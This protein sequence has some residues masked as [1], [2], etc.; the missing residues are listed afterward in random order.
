MKV[1]NFYHLNL[2]SSIK[3]EVNMTSRVNPASSTPLPPIAEEVVN[4][5]ESTINNVAGVLKVP[6]HIRGFSNYDLSE[7]TVFN[8]W[9]QITGKSF[10]SYG[11]SPVELRPFEL[12]EHLEAKGGIGKQIFGVYRMDGNLITDLG[13]PFDHTL[14]LALFVAQRHREIPFPFMRQAI[15]VV[16][17][18]EN[19]QAG[20]FRAFYQ[21]DVDVIA[22]KLELTSDAEC[23]ASLMTALTELNIGTFTTYINHIGIV[24]GILDAFAIPEDLRKNVLTE[25]DKA[26]KVSEEELFTNLQKI[27]AGIPKKEIENLMEVFSFR[28]PIEK[29]P[30]ENYSE[31]TKQAYSDL[32]EIVDTLRAF[33]INT[34]AIQVAPNIVRG[35]DY[36]TGLVFETFL[37]GK[38]QYG[39]IMSGGRYDKLVETFQ[40]DVHLEGVGGSIGLTRLFDILS[41]HGEIPKREVSTS[42]IFVG[43]RTKE[44]KQFAISLARKLREYGANV[45]LYP[46]K[47]NIKKQLTYASRLGV[48]VALLAMD[49]DSFV[50]K[51]MYDLQDKKGTDCPTQDAAIEHSL[52]LLRSNE[53][54]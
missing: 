18:G 35:L 21:A 15:G 38:E 32:C 10:A 49:H 43:Y 12:R 42:D 33:G 24:Y 14:P 54:N 30:I 13:L 31:Q 22:P 16:Y 48:P 27:L 11:F 9:K 2:I 19:P 51:N 4:D 23:L 7:Q 29:F 39:S 45:T 53:Q 1:K 52:Q 44:Q 40:S 37:H 36:Y 46:N 6:G 5:C 28:G 26:D 3:T 17:R 8:K 25:L 34:E 47:S 20:R 41:R 50:V